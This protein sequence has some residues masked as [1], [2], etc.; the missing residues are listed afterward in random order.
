MGTVH[1]GRLVGAHG[2]DRLV[3][4]KRLSDEGADVEPFLAEARLSARIH[5]PNV[6]QTLELG[7]HEGS[8]FIVM[9]LV[10]GVSLSRL[11]GRLVERR[12]VMAPEIAAWIV[13][14]AAAGLHAA[15]ELRSVDG[16]PLG[17][18]HRDVSPHNLLVSFSGH[19][20][21]T[22]FGIAKLRDARQATTQSGVVKGKFA[23]MSPEQ[24]RAQPLDRRSDVFTLGICLYES[25]V[26]ARLFQGESPADTLL[27]VIERV[28]P[29]P[30]ELRPEVPDALAEIALR[31]LAKKAD[32]RFATA[33]DL[34]DAL[35][36]CLSGRNA[37]IDE[38]EVARLLDRSVGAAREQLQESIR[39]ALMADAAAAAQSVEE[40]PP[41]SPASP[42]PLEPAATVLADPMSTAPDPST[43]TLAV[44]AGLPLHTDGRRR[45]R[46]VA[47]SAMAIAVAVSGAW[48]TLGR[49][50]RGAHAD[51][52]VAAPLEPAASGAGSTPS[53]APAA[54]SAPIDRAVPTP[55]PEPVRASR[56]PVRVRAPGASSGLGPVAPRPL[57]SAPPMSSDAP[58]RTL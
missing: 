30:R 56:P 33:A 44:A 1:V 35:R 11:L 28:P 13:A 48:W 49:F 19:V 42:T 14:Q 16:R 41:P 2:F 36:A 57:P 27:R 23:Y 24:A 55:T 54:P 4:I 25:L 38:T 45:W 6:V 46:V 40:G 8:P 12:E 21:V 17:L 50:G 53:V 20:Y 9:Q 29:S 39:A 3:A 18:V 43:G 47:G 10:E 31:C 58:F 15:H 32:D 5:H 52:V 37:H 22:D 26:G 34:A 51:A 7:E